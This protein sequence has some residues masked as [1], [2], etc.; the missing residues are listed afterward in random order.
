MV[1]VSRSDSKSVLLMLDPSIGLPF[2]LPPLTMDGL[3]D[4]SGELRLTG[5]A[6]RHLAGVTDELTRTVFPRI[7]E[8]K[9]AAGVA[10]QRERPHAG[11]RQ[12]LV[13]DADRMVGDDVLRT[14]NRKSS[15]RNAAGERLELH[16]AE[17]VG[18]A[19]KHEHVGARQM[20]SENAVVQHAEKLCVGELALEL[21]FLR[22]GADDDLGAG[23]I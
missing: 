11:H 15:N 19:W 9:S 20:R 13:Q 10:R 23:Q 7:V 3:R 18:Q 21:R 17:R 1:W 5:I 6:G 12:I 2:L 14:G 22:S 16:D 8:R 4:R